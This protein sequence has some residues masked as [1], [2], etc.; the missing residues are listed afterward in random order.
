MKAVVYEKYGSP[1]VLELR[2][3]EKPVP[4]NDEILIEV[5]FTSVTPGDWRLRKASPFLARLF[6][7]LFRP[8]RIKILG[9][10]VAGWVE[11]VGKDVTTF[12]KGDEVFAF[13]DIRFGGYAEFCCLR[14][15]DVVAK[16]PVNMS[17]EE[18]ATVPL[19]SL[20][21]L[22]FLRK[23][24]I[25]NG[26]KVMIYGASGSVGTFAVQLAKYFGAHV[27][28]VCSGGNADLVRSLGADEV[29]DYTK[30]DISELNEKFDLIFDAVAKTKKSDCKNILKPQ[31]KFTSVRGQSKPV[32]DDLLF[33]R[34]LI[35]QGHLKTVI[36]RKYRLEEI[37]EAHRYVEQYRKK[38][39]VAVQV[40]DD[41]KIMQ[42]L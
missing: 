1:E 6:N 38:G 8:K 19:G 7:G 32:K 27:T 36:D 3:V 20:T 11:A 25:A 12:K 41:A 21:A 34:D 15:K 29:I 40:V 18:A 10:E 28:G 42:P 9:F 22:N 33:I 5:C 26:Q 13:C 24:G 31:G 14:E 16:K 4:G 37:R 2:E 30:T 17:F 35:E 39:N 23:G